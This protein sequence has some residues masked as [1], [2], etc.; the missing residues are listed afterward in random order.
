MSK[1][2]NCNRTLTGITQSEQKNIRNGY[3]NANF[4]KTADLL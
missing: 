1:G 3:A 4:I 2:S